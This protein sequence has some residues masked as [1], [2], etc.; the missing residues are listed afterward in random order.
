MENKNIV[1]KAFTLIELLIVIAIIG[2][3]ASAVVLSIGDS[4][5]AARDAKNTQVL[6]GVRTVAQLH[7]AENSSY[8]GLC[9]N[10]AIDV[11]F[12]GAV[13]PDDGDCSG[14]NA[15][16]GCNTSTNGFAVWFLKS[17]Q[18]GALASNTN[19]GTDLVCLNE[20]KIDSDLT[21]EANKAVFAN[22]D[23]TA[24]DCTTTGN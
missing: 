10:D 5:G 23:G 8:T 12:Y 20:T 2:I 7:F 19:V 13:D 17:G 9:S 24:V 1:R 18:S 3:L 22:V 6:S 4:T 15:F 11:D 21:V 16:C 14:T